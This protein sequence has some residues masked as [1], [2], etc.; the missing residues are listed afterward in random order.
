[1][2]PTGSLYI[3]GCG[4]RLA[5]RDDVTA[6]DA[7]ELRPRCR[8]GRIGNGL[9]LQQPLASLRTASLSRSPVNRAPNVFGDLGRASQRAAPQ[10]DCSLTKAKGGTGLGLAI[11]KQIVEMHGGRIWVES[12]P[13]KGFTF[14]MEFPTRAEFRKSVQGQ[15]GVDD[16]SLP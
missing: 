6:A 4:P 12:T 1:M 15:L 5:T 8:G 13:G 2:L 3:L 7:L 14:Q 16:A 10:I 9:L 11:A